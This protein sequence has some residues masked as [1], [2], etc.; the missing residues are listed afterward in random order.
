MTTTHA[1]LDDVADDVDFEV[2]G[3]SLI[4]TFPRLDEIPAVVEQ[5]QQ[6]ADSFQI[7]LADWINAFAGSMTREI[8]VLTAEL[9]RRFIENPPLQPS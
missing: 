7:W 4:L 6:R 8:Y 5:E 2:V 9:H 1:A 3:T